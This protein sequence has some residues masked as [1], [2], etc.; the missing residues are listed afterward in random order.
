[1]AEI[2]SDPINQ[3][4]LDTDTLANSRWEDVPKAQRE[5]LTKIYGEPVRLEGAEIKVGRQEVAGGCPANETSLFAISEDPM[6]WGHYGVGIVNDAA[7]VYGLEMYARIHP[8][9]VMIGS[10][11]GILLPGM[12]YKEDPN[13]IPGVS[14]MYGILAEKG[15]T[16]VAPPGERGDFKTVFLPTE[17]TKYAIRMLRPIQYGSV[18]TKTL[19]GVLDENTVP[20]TVMEA[21]DR[22]IMD[23]DRLYGMLK[24]DISAI[25]DDPNH[26]AIRDVVLTQPITPKGEIDMPIKEAIAPGGERLVLRPGE[27][28]QAI[29]DPISWNNHGQTVY[30]VN[31]ADRHYFCPEDCLEV[32]PKANG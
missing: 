11:G 29:Q 19:S 6:Y 23:E 25:Y 10:D 24:Q 30:I 7:L 9:K 17:P 4:F 22:A 18:N 2:E 21:M 12:I 32:I 14:S 20:K 27:K 3:E 13:P 16:H 15:T 28:L 26:I 8:A 5:Q 1:M 31:K